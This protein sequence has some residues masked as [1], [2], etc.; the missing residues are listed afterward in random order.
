MRKRIYYKK[1]FYGG[2]AVLALGLLNPLTCLWRGWERF[3]LKDGLIALFLVLTG[4]SMLLR[5]LDREA[6][7][8]DRTEDQDERSRWIELRSRAAC[9]RAGFWLVL[10]GM[11]GCVA[12]YGLTENPAFVHMMLPLLALY[13]AAGLARLATLL[14]FERRG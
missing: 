5:S 12:G 9:Y 8:A 7:R 4:L 10:A 1:N 6:A 14:H 3:G 11:A 13:L 2:L